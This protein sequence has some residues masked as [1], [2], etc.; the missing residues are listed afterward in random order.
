M[1]V[2]PTPTAT[3]SA[4]VTPTVTPTISFTPTITASITPS[5]TASITP[6]RTGT[7]AVTPTGT[8]AVTPT[9][10]ITPTRTA[11]ITP[12]RT[13]TPTVTATGTP[14]VT[15]TRTVTPTPSSAPA[16]TLSNTSQNQTRITPNNAFARLELF[17]GLVR[18]RI[19]SLSGATNNKFTWLNSGTASDYQIRVQ[20]SSGAGPAGS[21]VNSWLDCNTN[22][23]WH[24]SRTSI[25]T[26]SCSLSVEIRLKSSGS[27]LAGPVT[28]T[29][30]V[31]KSSE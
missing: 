6:T 1:Y 4:T 3:V 17:G 2:T 31:T 29:L 15:P 14:A 11:S 27:V 19:T 7:P 5:I 24:L 28:W 18:G 13:V 9:R 10:T 21:A 23:G 25:G 30:S 16:V 22:P 20:L 12:T 26:T 8:P